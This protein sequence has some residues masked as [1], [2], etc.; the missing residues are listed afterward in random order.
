[1]TNKPRHYTVEFK[2]EAVRLVESS[3]KS[4]AQIAQE[5]GIHDNVLYR[6][7][8]DL[9]S[10]SAASTSHTGQSLAG[11]EA[12]I[13]QLCRENEV[14]RQERDVLKKAISI[15]SQPRP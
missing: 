2:Q 6:W 13:K 3:G 7:R 12:K 15:F 14:L 11:L 8:R 5:L 4:V 9:G 10:G 1:M